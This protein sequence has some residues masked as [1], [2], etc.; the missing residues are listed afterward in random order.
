M[1]KIYTEEEMVLIPVPRKHYWVVM[2]ALHKAEFQDVT[3]DAE[4]EQGSGKLPEVEY[5]QADIRL[6]HE[7]IGNPTVLKLLDL[8]AAKP[9]APVTFQELIAEAGRGFGV[10]RA[11][12]AGLTRLVRREL[13]RNNWPVSWEI[14]P[15]GEVTYRMRDDYAGWW[16]AARENSG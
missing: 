1:A 14:G 15:T 8:T 13:H 9:G 11:D 3:L 2:E 6:L 4:P 5:T 16:R 12:I 7:Q 10:A